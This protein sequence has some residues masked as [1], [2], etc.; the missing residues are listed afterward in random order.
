M[1]FSDFIWVLWFV[2]AAVFFVIEILTPTFFV[3]CFGVG[4]L[5]AMIVAII[6]SGK[7]PGAQ[8]AA[9]AFAS[10]AAFLALRPLARKFKASRSVVGTNVNSLSDEIAIVVRDVGVGTNEGEVRIRGDFWRAISADNRT[11]QKDEFVKVSR[12]DGTLLYV[13]AFEEE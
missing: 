5:A 12:I 3:V 9:F 4:A 7:S 8:L 13:R 2:V 10:F 1:I 11:F 6:S